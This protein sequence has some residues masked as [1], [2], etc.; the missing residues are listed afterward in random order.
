MPIYQCVVK[1]SKGNVK[2][3]YGAEEL[4][5]RSDHLFHTEGGHHSNYNVI[6]KQ[7]RF[8]GESF[9]TKNRLQR[10]CPGGECGNEAQRVYSKELNK[11]YRARAKEIKSQQK[12][13]ES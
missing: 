1:D 12:K 5:E 9:K 6:E 10:Y 11:R 3:V 8:C 7:C 4:Q 13:E 2:K